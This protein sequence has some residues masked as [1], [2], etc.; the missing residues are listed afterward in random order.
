MKNLV[1]AL[2]FFSI[3]SSAFASSYVSCGQGEPDDEILFGSAQEIQI[4]SGDDAYAGPVGGTWELKLKTKEDWMA[5]NKAVTASTTR[6]SQNRVVVTISMV[7][8]QGLGPVGVKYVLTDL[9][10]D[11]PTLE[12]FAIGGFAGGSKVGQ[13]SCASAND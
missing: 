1:A 13:Y 4:S 8:A 11:Y 12:K 5:A 2:V 9:Y 3:S 6:D 10:A 7:Q